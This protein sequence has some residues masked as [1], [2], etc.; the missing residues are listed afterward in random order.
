MSEV[1]VVL[2]DNNEYVASFES[3]ILAQEYVQKF[4]DL[5]PQYLDSDKEDIEDVE[6]ELLDIWYVKSEVYSSIAPLLI[7]VYQIEYTDD[8][9][10]PSLGGTWSIRRVVAEYINTDNSDVNYLEDVDNDSVYWTT[11]VRRE[12][13]T[14]AFKVGQ[15]LITKVISDSLQPD[16]VTSEEM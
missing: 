3:E 16:Q 9:S 1:Y 5:Y 4:K 10:A 2:K 13:R 11:Y 7:P 15:E 12:D 14:E 6:D 8:L